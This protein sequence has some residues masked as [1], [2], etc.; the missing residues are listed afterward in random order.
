MTEKEK[1]AMIEEALD[2][3]EGALSGETVLA[4]LEEYDSMAKLSLIVLMD[5]EFDIKV[6]GDMI[7][8]FNTVKDILAIMNK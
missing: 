5:E 6:T 7:K 2:L 4:D 8:G 1:I 3:E